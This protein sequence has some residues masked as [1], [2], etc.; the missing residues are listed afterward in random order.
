MTKRT[1]DSFFFTISADEVNTSS[2]L[3]ILKNQV[4]LCNL[5]TT[6]K[7]RVVLQGRLGKNNPN[8]W[9]YSI[10]TPRAQ[11]SSSGAHSH[12]R[13]RNCDAA[14]FDVYVYSK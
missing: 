2:E 5:T 1:S 8:A 11:S 6:N 14:F 13:I 4:K 9:K 10:K 3:K 12:Q 7:E